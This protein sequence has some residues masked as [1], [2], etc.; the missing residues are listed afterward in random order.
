MSFITS[1]GV[2]VP[3]L[4]AGGAAYGTGSQAKMNSAGTVGQVLTSAG[5]GV[6]TWS[7]PSTVTFPITVPQGGT[8]LTTLTANNVILGN[9]ASAPT[10]VA[11][12]TSGNLL[13]S[14]GT[15]WTSAAPAVSASGLT[16]I[17]TLTASTSATLTFT[18]TSIT[19]TYDNY[20][21]V[22]SSLR[23]DTGNS[24]LFMQ[25]ST[26]NGSTFASTAG[27]YAYAWGAFDVASAVAQYQNSTTNTGLKIGY[28]LNLGSV[29]SVPQAS[30]NAEI[31]LLNPLKSA[32]TT[33]IVGQGSSYNTRTTTAFGGGSRIAA[34]VNNAVKFFFDAGN[35]ASGTIQI[36]GVQKT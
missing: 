9:G 17:T 32:D 7:T 16:L 22:F 21:F 20:L 13:K 2:I 33:Q 5:A 26:D 15:T 12:G 28:L 6:P 23:A 4:T 27:D 1:P 3:P 8:N 19:S 31:Y 25:T 34:E 29:S 36:F 24:V 35:I 10:F 14:N 30:F 18:N 11:P